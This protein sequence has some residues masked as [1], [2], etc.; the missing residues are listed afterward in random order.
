[1]ASDVT[2]EQRRRM[3]AEAAYYLAQR[4]GF[5]AGDAAADWLAAE[6]QIDRM[7]AE[8]AALAPIATDELEQLM[9]RARAAQI[10]LAAEA[11]RARSQ[12]QASGVPV[13]RANAEDTGGLWEALT[14]ALR[15]LDGRR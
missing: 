14:A 5:A 7:L 2:E 11:L 8:R 9:S 3:I 10:E 1:M 12:R 15:E 4:R 6:A 13:P